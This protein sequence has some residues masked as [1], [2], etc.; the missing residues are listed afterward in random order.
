MDLRP[1]AAYD[2]LVGAPAQARHGSLRVS[3]GNVRASF[4]ISKL[5]GPLKHGEGKLMPLDPD[6][7]APAK[8][9]PLPP[10][11]IERVLK[12]W[13]EAGAGKN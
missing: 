6:T 10:N 12:P 8:P 2:A 7:G 4:L 5:V 1:G 3:P 9:S 13:I 11:F